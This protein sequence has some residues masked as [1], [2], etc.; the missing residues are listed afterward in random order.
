MASLQNTDF[1]SHMHIGKRSAF[2]PMKRQKERFLNVC[3]WQPGL[4][5]GYPGENWVVAEEGGRSRIE[6][7]MAEI[8]AQ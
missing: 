7:A 6:L 4:S 5:S 2:A 8:Q 1:L 3:L